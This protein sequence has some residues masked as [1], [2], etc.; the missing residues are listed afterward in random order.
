[1]PQW[2]TEHKSLAYFIKRTI[3]TDNLFGVDLMEEA[4]EIA[5]LRLFLA[6]VAS[7]QTVDQL[8]PLP[9]IDFNILAG[10]SLIG[11][12]RVEAHEFESQQDDLYRK[13]YRQVLDEKNR[14][15]DTYR[16]TVAW[17]GGMDLSALKVDIEEHKA[18]AQSTLNELLLDQW[19][20][21]GHPL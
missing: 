17:A 19:D 8:E 1:M 5:R 14:L 7:A 2:E 12:L 15:I 13:S 9:N 4:T 6:L 16:H 20:R 10:N 21:V 11:L 18:E 3:I